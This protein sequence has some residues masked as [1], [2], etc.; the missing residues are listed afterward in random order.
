[1]VPNSIKLYSTCYILFFTIMVEDIEVEVEV[2]VV[3]VVE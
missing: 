1:M 2:E 3:V